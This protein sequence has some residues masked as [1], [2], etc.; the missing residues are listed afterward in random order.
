MDDLYDLEEKTDREISQLRWY[1]NDAPLFRVSR[2]GQLRLLKRTTFSV[3]LNTNFAYRKKNS[4]LSDDEVKVRERSLK[5]AL[6]AAV[7]KV[8]LNIPNNEL[9]FPVR[10]GGGI[11]LIQQKFLSALSAE[12]G[13]KFH[14][15]HSHM[16]LVVYHYETS[17]KINFDNLKRAV[18]EELR[19]THPEVTNLSFKFRISFQHDL[20]NLFYSQKNRILEIQ[21]DPRRL[22]DF[23]NLIR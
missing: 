17:V 9:F 13:G 21:N 23:L 7:R 18:L 20:N 6:K 14:R 12:V 22:R 1:E 3:T 2:E 16:T 19:K 4:E 10:D 15:V 5:D 11:P 8:V